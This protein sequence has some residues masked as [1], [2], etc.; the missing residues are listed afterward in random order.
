[1]IIE[2]EIGFIRI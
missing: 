2:S 1:M